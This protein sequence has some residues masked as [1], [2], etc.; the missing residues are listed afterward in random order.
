M[1]NKLFD[2]CCSFREAIEL[3]KNEK[4]F[5]SN[6]PRFDTMSQFPKDC[7]DDAADLLGYYLLHKY[8]VYT[9]RLTKQYEICPNAYH[10]VLLLKESIVIDITGDQFD[11]RPKIYIGYEDE[12]LKNME[13]VNVGP[14]YDFISCRNE[15]LIYDYKAILEKL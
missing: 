1:E 3:V 14:N 6:D 10:C 12:W 9:Q 15:R 5:F 4:G 11:N 8:N 2:I 13:N 7:C